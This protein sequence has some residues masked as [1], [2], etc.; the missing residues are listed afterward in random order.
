MALTN[1]AMIKLFPLCLWAVWVLLIQRARS[2]NHTA[3]PVLSQSGRRLSVNGRGQRLRCDE[4]L[5]HG[6]LQDQLRLLQANFSKAQD[7]IAEMQGRIV[8]L[9]RRYRRLRIRQRF[10]IIRGNVLQLSPSAAQRTALRIKLN[11]QMASKQALDVKTREEYE[12]TIQS[13]KERLAE[14]INQLE[15]SLKINV[16]GPPSSVDT[17]SP[18]SSAMDYCLTVGHHLPA[19]DRLKVRAP[20]MSY[21]VSL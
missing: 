11:Q 14:C 21:S 7:T 17:D 20:G 1:D 9:R 19:E 10:Q 4:E 8:A 18:A 13:L 15:A 3:K 16:S 12:H 5:E 2:S 6:N